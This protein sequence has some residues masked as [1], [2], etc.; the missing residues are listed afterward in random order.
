MITYQWS[1]STRHGIARTRTKYYSRSEKAEEEMSFWTSPCFHQYI[2]SFDTDFV[3]Y[4]FECATKLI[5]YFILV[6]DKT[7]TYIDNK[8]NK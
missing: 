6:D 1:D 8:I 7:G 4:K 5:L 2:S 3:E